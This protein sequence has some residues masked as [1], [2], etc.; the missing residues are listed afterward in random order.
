MN[1]LL[2][3]ETQ[4]ALFAIVKESIVPLQTPLSIFLHSTS[5]CKPNQFDALG[6]SMF[7]LPPLRCIFL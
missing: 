6:A 4:T 1:N 5:E 2:S 3:E 7:P